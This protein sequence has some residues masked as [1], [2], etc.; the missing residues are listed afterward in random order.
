[1]DLHP[2]RMSRSLISTETGE[3]LWVEKNEVGAFLV[4]WH[5]VTTSAAAAEPATLSGSATGK[6]Q[7]QEDT[8]VKP[9]K[10]QLTVV[11]KHMVDGSLTTTVQD[12]HMGDTILL[13]ERENLEVQVGRLPLTAMKYVD[14]NHID[15]RGENK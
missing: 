13:Y 8:S 2:I 3:S 1:M 5:E 10:S 9:L 14:I 15:Q 12:L 6:K 7:D 4:L 11:F